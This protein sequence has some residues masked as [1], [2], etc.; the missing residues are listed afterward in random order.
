MTEAE[1]SIGV[2]D[3]TALRRKRERG[4]Y[5]RELIYSILDEGLICHFGF[6]DG[7]SVFVQPMAYGRRGD[8]LYLHGA[9]AN[10]GLRQLAFGSEACVTVTLLDGLVFSRSAFHHSMNYR[11]VMLI[12]RGHEVDEPGEKLAA[13]LAVV[14]HMAP[15]RCA[16][17]RP[18]TPAELRATSV[19]CFPIR[20]VSAKVRS[21]GPIEE[22]DDMT[23]AVWAGELPLERRTLV[24]IPAADLPAG[25][26]APGYISGYNE[27]RLRPT[28]VGVS[29][30][31]PE[32]AQPRG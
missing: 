22:P 16:D 24:P 5:D 30:K 26:R 27:L 2:T 32:G 25:L 21:G 29:E 23:L 4:S 11:S 9:A 7:G 18:P 14:E 6:I 12:G 20:E 28:R 17:A 19:V 10:R 3:R 15:G 1:C 8:N 13:V 31:Q